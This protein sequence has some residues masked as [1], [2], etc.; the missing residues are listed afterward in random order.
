MPIFRKTRAFG[1]QKFRFWGPSASKVG[2]L[3]RPGNGLKNFF[4]GVPPSEKFLGSWVR[5]FVARGGAWVN[6]QKGR[7]RRKALVETPYIHVLGLLGPF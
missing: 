2:V 4:E 3:N 5:I 6:F 1:G 7:M